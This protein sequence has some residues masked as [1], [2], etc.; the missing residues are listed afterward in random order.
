MREAAAQVNWYGDPESYDLRMALAGRHGVGMENVVIGC[1]IDD[2]L[3]LIVRTYLETGQTAVPRSAAILPLRTMSQVM[4]ASY[5]V[6]PIV[7][8]ATIW[9]GWP[10]R[11]IVRRR[12]SSIWRTLIIPADRGSLRRRSAPL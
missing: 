7:T 5:S 8:T 1:G 4:A 10:K 2:L 6:F 3:E 12:A 11:Q 9:L